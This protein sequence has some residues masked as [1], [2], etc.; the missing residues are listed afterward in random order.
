MLKFGISLFFTEHSIRPDVL[1]RDVEARGFDSVWS[2][3]HSHIPEVLKRYRDLG[4]ERVV[5]SVPSD[6]ADKVMPHLD[7]LQALMRAANA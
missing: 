3:E 4:V 2:G 6:P 1:A 5:F 7:E